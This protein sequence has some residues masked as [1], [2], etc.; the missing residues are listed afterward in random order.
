MVGGW[1][2]VL[3]LYLVPYILYLPPP[4][5]LFSFSPLLLFFPSQSRHK[6]RN[7]GAGVV[8]SGIGIAGNVGVAQ[9]LHPMADVIE[10]QQGVG[11]QKTGVVHFQFIGIFVSRFSKKRT[12]S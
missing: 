5:L 8:V 10:N 4:L 2:L 7:L 6:L 3:G 1:W 9:D 11:E 12:T